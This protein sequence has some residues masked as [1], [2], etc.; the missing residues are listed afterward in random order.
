M[1]TD[2]IGPLVDGSK[3]QTAVAE[4]LQTWMP[5][6][7]GRLE[8]D[9]TL[10]AGVLRSPR[11]YTMTNQFMRW[12]QDQLPAAIV[13]CP[14]ISGAR[15][16][17]NGV[18]RVVYRCSIAIVIAA[19]KA[20]DADRLAK[21]YA[22]AALAAMLQQGSL[23]GFASST[24][25]TGQDYDVVPSKDVGN[26][27]VAQNDFLIAVDNVIDAQAGPLAP[28]VDPSLPPGNWPDVQTILPIT[29]TAEGPSS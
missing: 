20:E 17:V 11:S 3:V 27:G 12:K 25:W 22:T 6:Y 28:A 19:A 13:V 29:I 7:L 23:G 26:L 5:T 2:L 24:E 16:G 15:R 18:Y 21:V 10:A 8:Q 4:T 1:T 14:G 9:Y